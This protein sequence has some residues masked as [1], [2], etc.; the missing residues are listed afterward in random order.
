MATGPWFPV[1]TSLFDGAVPLEPTARLA[2][3]Y[4][5]RWGADRGQAF[6]GY[7]RMA[8]DTG[9]SRSTAI[10]A[11]RAL[12]AAGLVVKDARPGRSNVYR[13]VVTN[14]CIPDIVADAPTG[15][16]GSSVSMAPPGDNRP[17]A[18]DNPVDTPDEA[19]HG[20][21]VGVSLRPGRGVT[22]TPDLD[23]TELDQLTHRDPARAGDPLQATGVSAERLWHRWPFDPTAVRGQPPPF[24][25]PGGVRPVVGDDG[26]GPRAPAAPLPASAPALWD[27]LMRAQ[28]P[29]C[30]WEVLFDG[31]GPPR[32]AYCLTPME[33]P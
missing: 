13:I 27:R 1:P 30:G 28:C 12:V 15:P 6:P 21:P 29:A 3:I 25:T 9:L 4:L 22:V 17:D 2:Y 19:G 10:R 20:D 5:L 24:R 26:W 23:L 7:T 11:I 31:G 14:P 8:A 33:V 18:V 16:T 32:C